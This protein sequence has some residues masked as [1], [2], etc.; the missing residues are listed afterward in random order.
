MR[1][2]RGERGFTLIELLIVLSIVSILARIALP[3][4]AGMVRDSVAAQVAADF[5]V[6]RSAATAQFEATGSYPADTP[7]GQVP[8]GLAAFLPQ[9]FRFSKPHY[10][11]AWNNYAVGDSA[12]GTAGQIVAVT[13][14]TDSH[15]LGL[16][17]V[18]T[19]GRNCT[20]WSVGEAHTFVVM[21]TLEGGR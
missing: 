17:L 12:D 10:Q 15:P 18:N 5:G 3:A 8:P 9:D 7:D 6:V 11:L 13:V 2:A 1:R 21:S 16:Q 4:Y 20:H 19:L 14:T